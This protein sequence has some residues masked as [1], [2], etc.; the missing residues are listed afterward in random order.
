MLDK[1]YLLNSRKIDGFFKMREK[2]E[3]EQVGEIK[4]KTKRKP[5]FTVI[6]KQ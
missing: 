6:A 4:Q 5:I 3:F 2:K 1:G